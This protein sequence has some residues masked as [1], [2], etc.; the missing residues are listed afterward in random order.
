[1]RLSGGF[2]KNHSFSLLRAIML[3]ITHFSCLESKK[4]GNLSVLVNHI[5]GAKTL[6]PGCFLGQLAKS[7]R[8]IKKG[9][10]KVGIRQQISSPEPKPIS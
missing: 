2:D 3:A 5:N 1:M 9:D 10:M 6:L 7:Y 4:V 8:N